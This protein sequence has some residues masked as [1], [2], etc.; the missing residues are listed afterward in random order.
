MS[1]GTFVFITSNRGQKESWEGR[2]E[3]SLDANL[4]KVDKVF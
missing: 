1:E 2:P 3:L 4:S